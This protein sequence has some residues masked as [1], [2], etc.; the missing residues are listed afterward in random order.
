[1]NFQRHRQQKFIG[2][3]LSI[4]ILSV[5]LPWA[6]ISRLGIDIN[7]ESFHGWRNPALVAFAFVSLV[8]YSILLFL[9]RNKNSRGNWKQRI[10][11]K[12]NKNFSGVEDQR[13]TGNLGD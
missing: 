7:L 8:M 10:E 3:A 1:M 2:I 13:R 6:I 12:E 5:L 11:T 4:G 9:F